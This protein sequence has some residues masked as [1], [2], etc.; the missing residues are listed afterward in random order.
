MCVCMSGWAMRRGD[1]LLADADRQAPEGNGLPSP[2]SNLCPTVCHPAI[3]LLLYPHPA[4]SQSHP[5]LLRPIPLPLP[6]HHIPP[7]SLPSTTPTSPGQQHQN[8]HLLP[9][10]RLPANPSPNQT[11]KPRKNTTNLVLHS[12]IP[13][14]RRHILRHVGQPFLLL[15]LRSQFPTLNRPVPQP[16][17]SSA[18]GNRMRPDQIARLV[19]RSVAQLIGSAARLFVRASQPR[20]VQSGISWAVVVSWG[21]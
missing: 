5:T 1:G 7:Q 9:R 21:W 11:Q 16:V 18:A 8:H 10:N 12:L 6:H 4:P 20:V 2:P 19:G 13:P 17:V 15:F 14:R 3:P